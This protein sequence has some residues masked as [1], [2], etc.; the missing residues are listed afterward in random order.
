MKITENKSEIKLT[1][2]SD[3]IK[4]IK[5]EIIKSKNNALKVVNKELVN[6]YFNL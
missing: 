2:Y 6:L 3:F 5:S 4:N 1:E